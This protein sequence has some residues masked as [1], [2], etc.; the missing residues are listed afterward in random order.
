MRIGE[1]AERVG[2][3]TRALRY[4]QQRGLLESART[5][6]G[7]RDCPDAA[8]LRVRQV[9]ALLD[10]GFSS[11]SIAILPPRARGEQPQVQLCPEVVREMSTV[12]SGIDQAMQTLARRREAS[13]GLLS[14]R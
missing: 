12:L 14:P 3:T 6:N 8:V 4:Y 9:R 1:L 5:S 2:T 11:D 7:Y 10:A 13:S